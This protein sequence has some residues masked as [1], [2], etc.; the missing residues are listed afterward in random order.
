M[1]PLEHLI[2]I[3]TLDIKNNIDNVHSKLIIS[4]T[5]WQP[6]QLRH[7]GYAN[8]SESNRSTTRNFS[9]VVCAIKIK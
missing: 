6:W 7:K 8:T 3:R 1:P 2:Y 5:L 4:I 9:T